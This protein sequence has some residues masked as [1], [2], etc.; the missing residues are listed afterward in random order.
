M[1]SQC[2]IEAEDKVRPLS[3][4]EQYEDFQLQELLPRLYDQKKGLYRDF[5][6]DME[7]PIFR[8]VK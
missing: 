1:D 6:K 2:F 5:V 3:E 7:K 8:R 4:D